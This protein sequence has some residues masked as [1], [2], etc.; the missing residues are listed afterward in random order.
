ML[1]AGKLNLALLP[2]RHP[3]KS[4]RAVTPSAYGLQNITVAH[5]SAALQNQRAVYAA[6]CP[7]DEA[8]LHHGSRNHR[9]YQ[10]IRRSQ[11]FWGVSILAARTR[12]DVRHIAIFGGANGSL[13]QPVLSL[14]QSRLAKTPDHRLHAS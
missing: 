4:N 14:R 3:V 5:R 8:Y 11:S 1:A 9:N 7:D 6:I 12:A 10:R 13:P 2:R